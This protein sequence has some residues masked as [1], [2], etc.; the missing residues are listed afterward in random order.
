MTDAKLQQAFDHS[1]ILSDLVAKLAQ[2]KRAPRFPSGDRESDVEHSYHL[3]LI[4]VELAAD[5]YPHLDRGLVAQFA[6]VHDIPEVLAGDVWT[7]RI[8]EE[9]RA[10]KKRAE[11]EATQK[12]LKVLPP[13][14]AG[15]LERYEKQEEP[16]ARF[17]R[18]VDK[19][20]PA[21][22]NILS[23]DAATFMRDYELESIEELFESRARHARELEQHFPEFGELSALTDLVF[24]E[25]SEHIARDGTYASRI[26]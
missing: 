7:F 14:L 13:T 15:L 25:S 17:V 9:E 23:G 22:V 3:S 8:T 24:K 10:S 26:K 12:L 18:Y 19:L 11:H 5:F 2:V 4:A 21:L 6:N 20:L 1:M 16:E